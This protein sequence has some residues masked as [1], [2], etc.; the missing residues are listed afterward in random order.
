MTLDVASAGYVLGNGE[1]EPLWFSGGLLT[2]KTTGDQSNGLLALAE[3][4]AP[5]GTGS[6][7]HR[8]RDEDEAW[9]VIEGEL[10]FWLGDE[11]HTAGPGSF[12]FGPRGIDH[13]FE[14]DSA[15]ARFLLMVTPAGFEDFTRVCGDPATSLTM[16]PPDL[17]S[18]DAR[19]LME[20]ARARGLEILDA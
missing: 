15:E 19:L 17:P 11:R 8:H 1:G 4:R 18:K 12:V 13:R 3:V 16:P 14:V 9:Y 20:A 2:Y 5:R 10:T 7:K 6:P